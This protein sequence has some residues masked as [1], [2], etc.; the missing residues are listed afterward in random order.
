MSQSDQAPC[1]VSMGYRLVSG[2]TIEV[3]GD[4]V[5][6]VHGARGKSGLCMVEL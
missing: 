1:D 4:E 6:E 5:E 3:D 2:V